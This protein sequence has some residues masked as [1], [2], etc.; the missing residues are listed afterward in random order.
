[1]PS[2]C[3]SGLAV[4]YAA[5]VALAVL[6]YAGG[7]YVFVSRGFQEQ[8]DRALHDDFEM[9]ERTLDKED[10]QASPPDLPTI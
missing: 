8:L 7:V 9:A 2:T 3:A 6:V 4:W 1:M 10:S 5:A